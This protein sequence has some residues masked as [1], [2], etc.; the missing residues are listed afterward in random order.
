MLAKITS[1]CHLQ[2]NPH[3]PADVHVFD[4]VPNQFL[5]IHSRHHSHHWLS[6]HLHSTIFLFS[7]LK[8]WKAQNLFVLSLIHVFVSSCSDYCNSLLIG[9]IYKS[10]FSINS[11]MFRTELTNTAKKFNLYLIPI[12]IHWLRLYLP[13]SLISP[14]IFCKWIAHLHTSFSTLEMSSFPSLIISNCHIYILQSFKH[15]LNFLPHNLWYLRFYCWLLT[16]AFS[17][18]CL[19]T[20]N[21]IL[22][23]LWDYIKPQKYHLLFLTFVWIAL[24]FTL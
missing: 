22:E 12:K 7:S 8:Y 5:L 24:N 18:A 1:A 20:V 19:I 16:Y 10:Q 9:L 15:L 23:C 13:S 21:V 3:L 4:H 14:Q 11:R 6:C 17:L 2:I